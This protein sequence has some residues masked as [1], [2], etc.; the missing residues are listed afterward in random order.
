MDIGRSKT[1]LGPRHSDV[2]GD[3]VGSR[4]HIIFT[5][6]YS[7]SAPYY[8]FLLYELGGVVSHYEAGIRVGVELAHSF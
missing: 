2:K 8:I 3:C 6:L 1:D 5:Y 7:C 4:M